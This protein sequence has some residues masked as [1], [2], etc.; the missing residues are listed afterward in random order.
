MR[1]GEFEVAETALILKFL[2][3]VDLFVDVGANLGYYTCLALQNDKPV[4]AFEPQQQ[5][6]KCLLQNLIANHWEDNVE[7]YP[8]ALSDKP[9]LLTLYGASGPSA[10]L[11]KNWAGYSSRYKK[12]VPVTTL[13]AVLG[14][15]FPDQQ[16]FIKIDV[17]GAEYGVLEGATQTIAR[18]RKPICLLEICLHEY[19][20]DNANP[21]YLQTFQLFWTNGYQAYT[22]A[23]VPRLV[24]PDDVSRWV[25]QGHCDS[26][27]FNY[28]F[29][30]ADL[31]MPF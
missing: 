31:A 16:L 11:V 4:V 8:M 17:E 5:N 2:G 13:D 22:A 14:S 18:S 15:R 1:V 24:T 29:I 20:P 25:A 7:V 28:L 9:G 23:D 6:L 10:S 30:D 26:G 19:H 12:T 3:Q 21:N 27:M